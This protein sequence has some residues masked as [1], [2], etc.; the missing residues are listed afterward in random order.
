MLARL[1]APNE[2][3]P[4]RWCTSAGDRG[5][6]AGQLPVRGATA[7]RRGAVLGPHAGDVGLVGGRVAAKHCKV[8]IEQDR[9]VGILG[10]FVA[11]RGSHELLTTCEQRSAD[12]PSPPSTRS[13]SAA[14]RASLSS[15][16]T[17]YTASW[18][19]AAAIT[20]ASSLTGTIA[21]SSRTCRTVQV[22]WRTPWYWRC[23]ARCRPTTSSNAS[24]ASGDVPTASL[25]AT[26]SSASSVTPS[27]CRAD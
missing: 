5:A 9:L 4:P 14:L 27:V 12:H 3:A 1:A 21:A 25:H 2:I 13:A 23:G 26:R 18:K 8:G 22:T 16:S 10:R 11:G 19:N 20:D 7:R 6:G 24:H 17:S 15:A